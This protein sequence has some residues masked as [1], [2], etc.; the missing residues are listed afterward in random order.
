MH[1]LRNIA[2]STL[3][4]VCLWS[5]CSTHLNGRTNN[6]EITIT[7]TTQVDSLDTI[8]PPFEL[9]DSAILYSMANLVLQDS[10]TI[11]Q[12]RDSLIGYAV[13]SVVRTID[14][15]H[16][17]VLK[18]ILSDKRLYIRDY[19]KIRQPFCPNF[20]VE[21]RAKTDTAIY[22]VSFNTDE[23][24]VKNSSRELQ[25]FK[26]EE[27]VNLARWAMLSFPQNAFYSTYL[28]YHEDEQD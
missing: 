20:A 24:A 21:F 26:M 7:D 1:G 10:D 3:G 6:D 22:L 13:D 9:I 16:L 4:T 27:T 19:P 5:S 18:F 25:F 15:G 28:K 12:T 11:R 8:T 2:L 23:I 17:D 14:G